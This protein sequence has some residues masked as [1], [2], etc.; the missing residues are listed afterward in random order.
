MHVTAFSSILSQNNYFFPNCW[1][2]LV[3]KGEQK[4][5]TTIKRKCSKNPVEKDDETD[6]SIS[7]KKDKA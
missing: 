1:S 2:N 7:V 3:K 4:M 5:Q 6:G